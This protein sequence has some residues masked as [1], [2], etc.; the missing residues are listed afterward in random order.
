MSRAD[1]LQ[2]A[3]KAM[4]S[5]DC[6]GA[7][8]QMCTLVNQGEALNDE[9]QTALFACFKSAAGKCRKDLADNAGNAEAK[10]KLEKC[11]NEAIKCL[12]TA[13]SKATETS[14]KVFLNKAL[15]DF[16]RYLFEAK[17]DA[18]NRDAALHCYQTATSLAQN[19][20][21]PCDPLRLNVALNFGVYYQET[22]GDAQRGL[23]ITT[24]AIDAARPA[25][26][27]IQDEKARSAPSFVLAMLLDNAKLWA[28]ELGQSE[29]ADIE[30]LCLPK[31]CQQQGQGQQCQQQQQPRHQQ[32]SHPQYTQPQVRA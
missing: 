5:G 21:K 19:G 8:Q 12:E 4:E 31:E 26:T 7:C 30:G 13:L 29:P 3:K 27:Q 15:G 24:D 18:Q 22:M 16:H 11:C 14:S 1:C 2:A 25:L 28:K 32:Q 23:K 20:L 9:E 6:C 17:R 10:Q